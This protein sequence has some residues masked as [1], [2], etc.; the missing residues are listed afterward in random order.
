MDEVTN[1]L[2]LVLFDFLA[3]ILLIH[4][5]E[6]LETEEVLRWHILNH[7]WI[8]S[9]FRILALAHEFFEDMIDLESMVELRRNFDVE[10][11][12]ALLIVMLWLLLVP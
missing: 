6:A 10:L 5:H 8:Y 3:A 12:N 2:E 7:R 11:V 1:I 4:F 9:I